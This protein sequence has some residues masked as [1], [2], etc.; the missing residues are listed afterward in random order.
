MLLIVAWLNSKARLD[1]S[2]LPVLERGGVPAAAGI[3]PSKVN[4]VASGSWPRID[5]VLA[6]ALEKFTWMPG[7][8]RRNS[9]MLPSA[10]LPRVSAE[11]ACTK[12]SDF[13]C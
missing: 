10:T 6:S 2:L 7:T 5:T 9:P 4:T 1:A 12:K 8:Y 3:C 11:I 13:F